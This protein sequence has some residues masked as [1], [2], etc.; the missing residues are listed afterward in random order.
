VEFKEELIFDIGCHKGE[1]TSHYLNEGYSVVAV[2]ANPKLVEYCSKKFE[3]YIAT[4]RLTILNVGIANGEAP[5]LPFYV[6]HQSSEWS[7]FDKEIG[8]RGSSRFEI[9]N[10]PCTTTSNLFKTY[11][12]PF[13][14]KVDIEGNDYLCLND[15]DSTGIKPAYV[16]CEACHLSWLET[17]Q[18]KGYTRFKLINQADRF[19]PLKLSQQKSWAYTKYQKVNR[20]IEKVKKMINP[21]YGGGS[22]SGPFGENTKGEWKCYEEIKKDYLNFY[23]NDLMTPINPGSW[24]DF[25]AAL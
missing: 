13:Y 25:H 2:E 11:G 1:D 23:Q 9:I 21:E 19:K 17:L 22:A 14:M 15:I 4:N 6:N 10:I 5:I 7:S 20:G 24:L 16:S 18:E 8:T 12:V 3:K